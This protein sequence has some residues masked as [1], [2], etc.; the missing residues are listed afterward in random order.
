M[1]FSAVLEIGD[2]DTKR[3]NKQYLLTDFRLVLSRAYNI[4]PEGATSCERLELTMV[5]ADK[6]D[7]FFFE[8]FLRSNA[9]TGRIIISL[10]GDVNDSTSE[11]QEIY[12]EDATCFSLTE[13]YDIDS[14]R[15]RSLKL[16]LVSDKISIED[17]TF[18]CI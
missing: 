14:S 8:W 17:L 13:N 11:N 16:A 7:L 15:R 4:V 3:Y 18:N 10:T 9:I 6:S 1:A 5:S 12:F 2:N